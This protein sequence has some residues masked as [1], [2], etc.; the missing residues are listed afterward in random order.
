[1]SAIISTNRGKSCSICQE[2]FRCGD[3]QVTHVG[4]E[5]HDGFH[6]SCLAR[7][8][9]VNPNCP[10]DRKSIDPNSL[11]TR[12]DS[13]TA[14]LRAALANAAYAACFGIPTAVATAVGA[15]GSGAVERV[16]AATAEIAGAAAGRAAG[17][18]AGAAV[19][20]VV[21]ATALIVGMGI[22]EGAEK[23][24]DWI[25]NRRGVDRV[26]RLNIGIGICA[27]GLVTVG[28]VVTGI[29]TTTPL[30]AIAATGLFGGATA[31]ILSLIRR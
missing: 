24:L 2:K 26:A 19:G 3:Q 27:G 20:G 5:S 1:M 30:T 16:I 28:A 25:L 6:K 9:A 29:I 15:V 14:R 31:G 17:I 21:V 7:W 10:L 11:T 23:G 22:A 4:G 12:T 8:L 18:A 13:I